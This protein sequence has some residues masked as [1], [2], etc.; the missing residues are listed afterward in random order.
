M[1]TT[2]STRTTADEA[3]VAAARDVHLDWRV[4]EAEHLPFDDDDAFDV[5]TSCVG[6]MF[7]PHHQ[8]TAAARGAAATPVGRPGSRAR[9]AR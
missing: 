4:S 8:Q 1:T 7:A 2:D 9:P 3:D 5:V 6:A